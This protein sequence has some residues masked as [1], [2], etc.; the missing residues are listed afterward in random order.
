MSSCVVAF[1]DSESSDNEVQ[2]TIR[3]LPFAF[4]KIGEMNRGPQAPSSVYDLS[5]GT[6]YGSFEVYGSVYTNYRYS[7]HNGC[8]TMNIS[9]S[10]NNTSGYI[11]INC[12]KKALLADTIIA[13]VRIPTNCS[14]QIVFANLSNSTNY[15][16]QFTN[17][18]NDNT[19][20][21]N[22]SFSIYR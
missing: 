8:I 19:N 7:N 16:F 12:C 4:Y 15:Y 13:S 5:S 3:E 17:P 1:A 20:P 22:G 11:V 18:G 10:T 9:T 21:V 2:V 14:Q 6:Y